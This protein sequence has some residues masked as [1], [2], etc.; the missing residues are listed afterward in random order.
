MAR[1]SRVLRR[2]DDDGA[3]KRL[4][5]EMLA[6]FVA[7]AL[8]DL[9]TEVDW[10]R[11]PVFLEQKLRP[12]L[13]QAALD[14]RIGDLVAQLWLKDGATRWLLIH[15]EV[16]DRHEDDFAERMY[17]YAALIHMHFRLRRTR[18]R[19]PEV[20]LPP[21][22][23]G[24]IGVAILTDAD[25][26]WQ[27]GPFRW[28]WGDEGLHYRYRLLKLAHWRERLA[29]LARD[30]RP[31]A[32]VIQTWLAVQ[33]ARRTIDDQAGVRREI[34]RQVLIA[35]RRGW[36]TQDQAV[37]IYIFL[38]AINRLPDAL[39]EM[40]DRELQLVEEA[41]MAELLTRWERQGWQQGLTKGLEQ[42]QVV[43]IAATVLRLLGKKGIALDAAVEARIRGLDRDALLAL[44]EAV[45]DF[46]DRADLDVWLAAR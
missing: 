44:A 25:A 2:A 36:L 41:P 15:I 4:L 32:W 31:F 30:E 38:D 42:G 33:A 23:S 11:A 1:Q 7:F 3:W 10:G 43:G 18:R 14:R 34:G 37:A 13:R 40:I 19:V 22:P 6:E 35:R 21:L 26:S 24:M 5:G 17:L 9:Y 45:L 29:E 46:H 16:Q 12:I 27:P 20:E 28:G 39:A 8:P